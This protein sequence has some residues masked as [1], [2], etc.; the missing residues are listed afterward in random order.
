MPRSKA[1]SLRYELADLQAAVEGAR[2]L[3]EG[4]WEAADHHRRTDLT[5][6]TS[7]TLALIASRL[8]DLGRA[9]SGSLDPAVFMVDRN[10]TDPERPRA[11]DIEDQDVVLPPWSLVEVEAHARLALHRVRVRASTR[12]RGRRG[13][14]RGR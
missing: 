9:V 8:G 10:A 7:A 12:R 6:S 5:A 3:V 13:G 11:D 14:G 1:L 2:V 4:L